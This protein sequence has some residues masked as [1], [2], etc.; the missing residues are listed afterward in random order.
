MSLNEILF[1]G[2]GGGMFSVGKQLR[3]SGGIVLRISGIQFH[4]DPGPGALVRAKEYGVNPR[5]TN[6]LLTSHSALDHCNDVNIMIEAMTHSGLDKSGIFLGSKSIIYGEENK[7]PY[8]T[9]DH[10]KQIE[11]YLALEPGNKVKFNNNISVV[12]LKTKHSDKTNIGFKFINDKFAIGYT[13]DTGYFPELADEL[14]G[15][16]VLIINNLK[17]FGH[18]DPHHLSSDDTIKLLRQV[19]PKLAIITHFDQKMLEQDPI[20]QARQIQ[21]QTKVQTIAA[22]DGMSVNPI[23][24]ATTRDNKSMQFY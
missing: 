4:L 21:M 22:R 14:K 17:P 2:T 13:S 7:K 18:H 10:K 19:R 11:K 24:Y 16:E 9:R 6:V 8:L 1:L 23:T 12:A 3:A 20:Y 15:C 5:E